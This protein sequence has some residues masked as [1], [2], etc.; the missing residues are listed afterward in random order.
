MLR[1]GLILNCAAHSM[2]KIKIGQFTLHESRLQ[3][4]IY[5]YIQLFRQRL[6]RKSVKAYATMPIGIMGRKTL[7]LI[8]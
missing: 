2:E 8:D 1:T 4:H 3:G 5:I 7:A 6:S